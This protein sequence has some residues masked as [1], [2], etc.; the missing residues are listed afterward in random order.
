MTETIL[1]TGTVSPINTTDAS[2]GNVISRQSGARAAARGPQRRRPTEPAAW[3]RVP[4]QYSRDRLP[5]S[6]SVSGARADQI[7]VTLDG[8]DVNDPQF[9]TAYTSALRVTT[10]L[11]AGIPRYHKQ[12]RRR[13]RSLERRTGF[14]DH[15]ERHQQLPRLRT[16]NRA[17]YDQLF[18][19]TSTSCGLSGLEKA[20]ARQEDLR[21]CGGRAHPEGQAV[22]FCQLRAPQRVV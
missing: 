18:V 8:V 9:G 20:K 14:A 15:Q 6:G 4:A 22:L 3:C 12:L 13:L 17:R 1:V 16:Y 21:R 11:A 19:V 7:N 5:R 10:G 2:L